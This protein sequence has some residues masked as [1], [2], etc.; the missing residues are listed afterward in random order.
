MV[1]QNNLNSVG[2]GFKALSA[3]SAALKPDRTGAALSAHDMCAKWPVM[4]KT[5]IVYLY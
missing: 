3:D 5:Y 1:E 4:V 2:E